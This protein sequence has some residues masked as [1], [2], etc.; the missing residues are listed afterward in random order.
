[1]VVMTEL[2]FQ[3]ELQYLVDQWQLINV[4][5]MR[6][7]SVTNKYVACAY[8]EQYKKDIVIKIGPKKVI[9]SEIAALDYFQGDACVK[10]F[11]FDQKFSLNYSALML[12]YIQLGNN[13][14]DLFFQ[15]REDESIE[16]FANVVKKLHKNSDQEMY[17]SFEAVAQR[18]QFLHTF[19]PRSQ[20]LLKIL[21][22]VQQVA[23]QLVS[24][25]DAQFLLHGDLH[26]ENIIQKGTDWLMIDPQGVVGEIAYEIGAFIRN[27]IFGL[28]EQK[29]IEALLWYRFEK[30]SQLLNIGQQ[31]IIN[32]SF[33]QAVLAACYAE[34]DGDVKAYH[35][36]VAVAQLIAKITDP[37][38]KL[39]IS[40]VTVQSLVQQQF[41]QCAH[42]EV[43][44]IAV[45][46]WDNKTFHLGDAMSIRM[47]SSKEYAHQ[48]AK[49]QKWIPFLASHLSIQ[50][51]QPIAMGK[52]SPDY[53]FSWSV[54]RWLDG[55]SANTLS[56]DQLDFV[57][58]AQQLAQFLHEMHQIDTAGGPVTDRG[59]SPIFYDKQA[60]DSIVALEG[61]IDI[62]AATAVWEK[63]IA[64]SWQKNPV[65][66]HGDLSS[67][68]ILIQN[69]QLSAVIDFGSITIGDPACDLVIAWTFLHGKS[70]QIFKKLVDCDAD[71]WARAAGWALWKAMITLV[72]MEDRTTLQARK[73]L[74]IINDVLQEKF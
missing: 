3:N 56:N 12:E 18:V 64:S 55:K 47:P 36:F 39:D 53:P 45:S 9:D 30:L 62:K 31:R 26:H 58:I 70:R 11:Q 71:T 49:E 38:Y 34:Q 24:T 68:N 74:H 73:Q 35:Y 69:C 22:Q 19:Q 60:R 5:P 65:W 61:L 14:K 44:S 13:L 42:L 7:E 52:P 27:P 1:M 15:D 16:I 20:E 4:R 46:G 72:A 67:G 48:V 29:N 59:G 33:V 2:N 66:A 23:D 28:L 25:Q 51:A 6:Y 17:E 50:I 8:S 63:A 10:L 54:Y 21:P 41:P 43:S 32:W 37:D 57:A 40:V